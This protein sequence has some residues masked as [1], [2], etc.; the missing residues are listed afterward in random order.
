MPFLTSAILMAT[1]CPL[2]L[3]CKNIEVAKFSMGAAGQIMCDTLKIRM[4]EASEGKTV[5]FCIPPEATHA[6]RTAFQL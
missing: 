4:N 2:D 5:Y 6:Q 1:V 3:P